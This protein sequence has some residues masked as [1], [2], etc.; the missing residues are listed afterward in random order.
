MRIPKDLSP[1]KRRLLE[2]MLKKKAAKETAVPV[3]KRSQGENRFPLS[4]S[5]SGLWFLSRTEDYSSIYNIPLLLRI[6][7]PLEVGRIESALQRLV[8]RHESLRTSFAEGRDGPIQVVANRT[9][10]SFEHIRSIDPGE[11]IRQ[12]GQTLFD[13]STA[14]LFKALLI[15]TA[16]DEFQ[17]SLTFHHI[18]FDGWSKGVFYRELLELYRGEEL[19]P[20]GIQYAEYS[21]WLENR[22]TLVGPKQLGYWK[23]RFAESPVPLELPMRG[24]RP[25]VQDHKRG[26]RHLFE[27]PRVLAEKVPGVSKREGSTVFMFLL[28]AFKTLLYRYSGQG[29]IVVGTPVAN[30][31]RPEFRSVVGCFINMLALRTEVHESDLFT[32]LLSSV[33]RTC[34]EGFANAE[35]PFERVVSELSLE[36]SLSR[37]PLYQVI[38]QLQNYPVPPMEADGIVMSSEGVDIGI[39][40]VDLT[41]DIEQ[42]AGDWKCLFE[43]NTDLFTAATVELL[44]G[45]FVNVLA[46]ICEDPG[47][48]VGEIPLLSNREREIILRDW[49]STVTDYRLEVCTH[50]LIEQQAK[51]TPERTAILFDGK[52][53]SYAEMNAHA[54][55]LAH[56]LIERGVTAET[57]V[58]VCLERGPG[59]VIAELAIWK[60]GGAYVPLDPIY[61][62]ERIEYMLHDSDAILLL[63]ESPVSPAT[64]HTPRLMM[65]ELDLSSYPEIDPSVDVSPKNLAYMIYTSGSTGKPKAVQIEHRAFVNFLLSMQQEPGLGPDDT[66]LAITTPCFDI[67][68]LEL[69]LPLITGARVAIMTQETAMDGPKLTEQIGKIGTVLQATPVTWRMLLDSGW[70]GAGHLK[71]LCGGESWPRELAEALL[72]GGGELWNMYG[73]TETTVWSSIEQVKVGASGSISIG[74]PIANTSFYILD[75]N[76]QPVPVGVTGALWIGGEGLSR[77]Y[78]KRDQLTGSVFVPDPFSPAQGAKMYKT[79][80]LAKWL[81]DGRVECLGRIDFQVKV[82]GFRIELEEIEKMME[83][84]PSIRQAVANAFMGP[85]GNNRL[86]GY[87]QCLEGHEVNVSSLRNR[88][89][90]TLPDYMVPT[91]FVEIEKIPLTPNGKVDRKAL[92]EIDNLESSSGYAPPRSPGEQVIAEIWAEVLGLEKVGIRD[93]FFD[94]GGYSL[95]A[96]Q[97]IQ[98]L[99]E[100]G[101]TLRVE[102]LFQYPTI[103]EM[104]PVITCDFAV[105]SE[106]L[107]WSSLITLKK[108]DETRVP[109]FFVHTAPGD[110]LMYSNVI[111]HMDRRQPCY[112]FQSLGL[113]DLNNIHSTIEGMAAHY[114]TLLTEFYPSGPYMLAGWCYGGTVA[115]EM[116][117]QLKTRGREVILLAVFD[118]SIQLP[119][120]RRLRLKYRLER[121]RSFLS[122]GFRAQFALVSGRIASRLRRRPGRDVDDELE[123]KVSQGHLRNRSEVYRLNLIA[124]GNYRSRYYPGEIR[125]FRPDTMGQDSIPNFSMGWDLMAD[126]YEVFLIPGDHRALM[127]EPNAELLSNHLQRSIDKATYSL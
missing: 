57:K 103:E 40:Q 34:L 84:D 116:A 54:N 91:V 60:A 13:L 61:P 64:T 115:V 86:A 95:L 30:R 46:A 108:G 73:P 82:R 62:S 119:A 99:T 7:G 29:D 123:V 70:Q 10:L 27:I 71:M 88:L 55:R 23:G 20:T 81:P 107:K 113:N 117:Q 53:I 16:D 15:Q 4:P 98:R 126:E 14:P 79:G 47:L 75:D 118:T 18:I 41:L 43:Y 125:L 124:N 1:E 49:N 104:E 9:E 52:E 121:F 67:A 78:Y 92:P 68:G 3:L 48:T 65:D 17:L 96:I 87:F 56:L 59:L 89:K 24:T 42:N 33:R 97:L 25:A 110:V 63:T 94:I 100:A 93:N 44:A 36:R 19:E 122:I 32:D 28:A 50:G 2:L 39:S 66:L 83:Q 22:L 111:H 112:G 80:D 85:D 76:L 106:D 11:R 127:H 12:A 45:H 90:E 37:H 109:I 31:T 35:L 6:K 114:V 5:Q 101:Y 69:F 74:R 21:A 26:A 120:D 58:C 102:D 38:F 51:K 105:T 77:G 8:A 72:K